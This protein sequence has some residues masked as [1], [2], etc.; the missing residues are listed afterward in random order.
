MAEDSRRSK[1]EELD[2]ESRGVTKVV[3]DAIDMDDKPCRM[4]N[5]LWFHSFGDMEELWK[6]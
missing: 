5:K 3:D 4:V 6:E 1:L 2:Q